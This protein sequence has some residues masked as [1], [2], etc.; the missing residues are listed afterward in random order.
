MRNLLK[1]E[2]S[3]PQ[4]LRFN[5]GA[6]AYIGVPLKSTSISGSPEIEIPK[7]P[8]VFTAS[9]L[10]LNGST[11]SVFEEVSVIIA[12][13]GLIFENGQYSWRFADNQLVGKVVEGLS[14]DYDRTIDF[15]IGCSG[16]YADIAT[17]RVLV[18]LKVIPK[19][20]L[21]LPNATYV[22]GENIRVQSLLIPGFPRL[23]QNVICDLNNLRNTEIL[24][25]K[26]SK[27]EYREF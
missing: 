20:I 23:Y 3:I 5:N 12:H 2:I 16:S 6:L 26:K 13:A 8:H 18:P 1:P 21:G 15:V 25:S 4:L 14:S 7:V 19:Q 9:H 10:L 24:S 22:F 11:T 17:S 27:L